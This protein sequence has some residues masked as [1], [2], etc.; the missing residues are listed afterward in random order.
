MEKNNSGCLR[1]MVGCMAG[2]IVFPFILLITIIVYKTF[3]D[4]IDEDEVKEKRLPI[5]NRIEREYHESVDLGLSVKW[6]TCNVG[7]NS[8]EEFGEYYEWG[9]TN[10]N[11]NAVYLRS[12][13]YWYNISGSQYDVARIKWGGS[14]R[15]PT[16]HEIQELIEKCA[17]KW[18]TYNGVNGVLVTGPNG[19]SIFLPAASCGLFSEP[20]K[21]HPLPFEDGTYWSATSKWSST[22]KSPYFVSVLEFRFFK[23][24][25]FN[26]LNF[27]EGLDFKEGVTRGFDYCPVRPVCDYEE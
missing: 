6:A 7:A 8:P 2:C 24:H 4:D 11:E 10:E 13:K 20:P 19:N 18:T 27:K 21:P 12:K 22:S 9:A 16:R 17:K 1:C 14:W 5:I 26:F 25:R 3:P 15:L 23:S